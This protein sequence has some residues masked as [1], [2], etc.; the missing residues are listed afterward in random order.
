ME[1]EDPAAAAEKRARAAFLANI[2]V[3]PG[4]GTLLHGERLLGLAQMALAG[5][6]FLL[7][8]A[9]AVTLT[10][11]LVMTA[12][13]PEGGGPLALQ[14]WLGLL[15]SLASLAWAGWT[16]YTRW[17]KVKAGTSGGKGRS[18]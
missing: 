2:T 10:M 12:S 8:C 16:G 11:D 1:P 14:G 15:L 6:G 18:T 13:W 4:L 7:M 17:Q 5:V 3:L 9:W